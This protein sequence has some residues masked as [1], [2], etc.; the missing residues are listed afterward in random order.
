M[1]WVVITVEN[2]NR[3]CQSWDERKR[4]ASRMTP[5]IRVQATEGT[6]VLFTVGEGR[7]TE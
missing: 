7:G 6:A 4:E 1:V 5:G 3:T 2:P